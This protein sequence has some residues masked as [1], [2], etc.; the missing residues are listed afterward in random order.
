MAGLGPRKPSSQT[1]ELPPAFPVAPGLSLH[2]QLCSRRWGDARN[3]A[4]EGRNEDSGPIYHPA[5]RPR[6]NT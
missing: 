4:V 5:V 2:L 6:E 1:L 3:V